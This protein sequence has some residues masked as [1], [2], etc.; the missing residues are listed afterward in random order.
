MPG[1][2]QRKYV[3]ELM[4]FNKSIK[5]SL[6]SD[7]YHLVQK[8]TNGKWEYYKKIDNTSKINI[9]HDLQLN[10]VLKLSSY[11]STYDWKKDDGFNNFKDWLK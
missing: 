7:F 8:K 6:D 3:K 2:T 9:R 1:K 11:F 5:K 4:L 10:K